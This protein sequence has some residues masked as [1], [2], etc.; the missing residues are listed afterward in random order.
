V[1]V[2]FWPACGF[3]ELQRNERGWLVPG[4]ACSAWTST[5]RRRCAPISPAGRCTLGLA[6]S[7]ENLLRLKP[8]N[9]LLNL[10]LAA[11]T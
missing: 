11:A 2:D 6:M 8:Q 10:P 4:D 1:S 9:L 5:T 3:G 7:D